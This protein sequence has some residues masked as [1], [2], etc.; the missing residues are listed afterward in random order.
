MMTV[1]EHI[2]LALKDKGLSQKEAAAIIGMQY[3]NLSD[4]LRGKREIPLKESILLD[5]LLGFQPG[6][7]R[8]LSDKEKTKNFPD[9]SDTQYG[10][11]RKYI[12]EKINDNGGFWSYDEI[13]VNIDTDTLI[14]KGLLH[15]DFEDIPLLFDL[16]SKTHIK[17]VWKQR[18]LTQGKRLN[19]LNLL[20]ELLFFKN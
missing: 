12:L 14:E 18:L 10:K 6:E 3:Q 16:W 19:T 20:L 1:R 13:P 9:L 8:R 5:Q 17:R 4:A 7:I 11:T 2:R 15:L